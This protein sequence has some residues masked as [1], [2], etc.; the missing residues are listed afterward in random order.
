MQHMHAAHAVNRIVRTP[1][2][3]AQSVVCAYK[4][5]GSQRSQL[6]SSDTSLAAACRTAAQHQYLFLPAGLGQT[7]K[8][9][10]Q[11]GRITATHP[12]ERRYRWLAKHNSKEG[13]TGGA[14]L[15]T[16]VCM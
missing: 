8:T 5:T 16:I 9:Q 14:F 15:A 7:R 1:Q 12:A 6:L 3:P 13:I 10:Q 4:H 2:L 11:K